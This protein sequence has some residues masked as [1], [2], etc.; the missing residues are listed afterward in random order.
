MITALAIVD[1]VLKKSLQLTPW[2]STEKK[3][4]DYEMSPY[5]HG[6]VDFSLWPSDPESKDDDTKRGPTRRGLFDD[7]L[8][9]WKNVSTKVEHTRLSTQPSLASLYS[10]KIIASYWV[11]M[12]EHISATLSNL[13]HELW[14]LEDMSK[15]EDTAT[16]AI[17]I[18]IDIFGPLLARGNIWRRRLWWYLEDMRWN[19][20]AMRGFS[21]QNPEPLQYEDTLEDFTALKDRLEG[22]RDR[23]DSLMRTAIGAGSLIVSQTSLSQADSAARITFL[24]TAFLPFFIR[25]EHVYHA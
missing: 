23:I 4:E 2:G 21:Q 11:V 3:S 22:C 1:P 10:N 14:I 20:E 9:Y 18:N 17:K 7:V 6:Y 12:L 5:L 15:A 19:M 25:S 24:A 8:Y 16:R 13:E